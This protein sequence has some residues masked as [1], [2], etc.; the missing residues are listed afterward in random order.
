MR[1]EISVSKCRGFDVQWRTKGL[2]VRFPLFCW[3]HFQHWSFLRFCHCQQQTFIWS[4]LPEYIKDTFAIRQN[5][6]QKFQN[7]QMLSFRESYKL[8]SICLITAANSFFSHHEKYRTWKT[9]SKSFY[10]TPLRSL[11]IALESSWQTWAFSLESRVRSDIVFIIGLYDS[12]DSEFI[13]FFTSNFSISGTGLKINTEQFNCD[14]R[15]NFY[16]SK[17]AKMWN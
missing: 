10:E 9:H 6:L 13:S 12:I 5:H 17:V 3:W 1:K 7:A 2:W 8:S 14:N 11:I 15:R 4:A 16:L